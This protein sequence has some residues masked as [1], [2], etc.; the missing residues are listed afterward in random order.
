[1]KKRVSLSN[2]VVVHEL[3]EILGGLFLLL[4]CKDQTLIDI[5]PKLIDVVFLLLSSARL[6]LLKNIL[7]DSAS[8]L[9]F[10]FFKFFLKFYLFEAVRFRSLPALRSVHVL[11][12]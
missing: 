2:K 4:P 11:S 5:L 9:S 6:L 8:I 7:V 3:L 10:G 12:V 1:M